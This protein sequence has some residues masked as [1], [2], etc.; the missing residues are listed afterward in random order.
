MA[1]TA[2][3]ETYG[4]TRGLACEE[5]RAGLG[6]PECWGLGSVRVSRAGV[7]T[8]EMSCKPRCVRGQVEILRVL[9]CLGL[10]WDPESLGVRGQMEI[11]RILECQ[12]L[13]A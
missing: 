7:W 10:G 2:M 9:G 4:R 12:R 6:V 8:I 1:Q 5:R 13:G 3:S 11:L